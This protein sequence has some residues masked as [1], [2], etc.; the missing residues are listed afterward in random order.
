M[1]IHQLPKIMCECD[2]ISISHHKAAVE[3]STHLQRAETNMQE[4]AGERH[5]LKFIQ[6]ITI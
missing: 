1:Q 5:S 4:I 6:R 2:N 3:M